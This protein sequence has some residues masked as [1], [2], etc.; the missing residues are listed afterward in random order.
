MERNKLTK[1]DIEKFAFDVLKYLK[2]W[3]MDSDVVIYYNG[4]RM[5]N[6][7]DWLNPDAPPKFVVEKDMSPFDYFEYANREHILSMS[8]EGLLYNEL[9]YNFG[10]RAEGLQKIFNK[11]GCYWEQGNAWNLSAYP[12]YDDMEIEFTSYAWPKARITLYQWDVENNP[13]ELQHIMDIW[14]SLAT[15]V[16]DKGSCVIGAGFEFSWNGNDYKMYACSP[17]QGSIS[18]ETN[19]DE[20]KNMLENIGATNIVYKWGIMD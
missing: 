5:Q 8:F 15:K 7:Y 14:Y 18:W 4:I 11:Y 1:K 20:I 13:S 6:K 2:R 17:Y 16:G 10:K 3:G 12:I 9:N 19:K